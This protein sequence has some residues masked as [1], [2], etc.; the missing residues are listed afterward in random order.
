M[1]AGIS[2]RCEFPYRRHGFVGAHLRPEQQHGG[3]AVNF[4]L[5]EFASAKELA[6]KGEEA[7]RALVPRIRRLLARLASPSPQKLVLQRAH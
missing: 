7:A 1:Y 4:D 2:T 5:S 6:R 3:D